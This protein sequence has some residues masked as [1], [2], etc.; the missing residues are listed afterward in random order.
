MNRVI[1]ANKI[2]V[3]AVIALGLG[4]WYER[5][6]E[7]LPKYTVVQGDMS[8]ITNSLQIKSLNAGF[9]SAVDPE[10]EKSITRSDPWGH[11]YRYTEVTNG[12][13]RLRDFRIHSMGEDGQSASGGN[14]PDDINSW[15]NHH[16]NYYNRNRLW[17]YLI[18]FIVIQLMFGVPV[19]G[20]IHCLHLV[21]RVVFCR[22][23]DPMAP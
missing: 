17:Q 7:T 8:S 12:A 10:L 11:P 2:V 21:A 16:L 18:T 13:S 23:A 9:I 3:S 14:D 15:D 6:I 22:A 20:L 5:G 4:C 1:L 19:F